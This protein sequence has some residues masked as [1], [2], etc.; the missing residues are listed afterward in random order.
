[1]E[2]GSESLRSIDAANIQVNTLGCFP[3]FES[4]GKTTL[5]KAVK[6]IGYA[7]FLIF[8]TALT[9][10]RQLTLNSSTFFLSFA[11]IGLYCGSDQ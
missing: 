6:H 2:T 10:V 8:E 5:S 9:T 4:Q 1:M 11:L 3:G 7:I